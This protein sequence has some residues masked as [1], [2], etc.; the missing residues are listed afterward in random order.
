LVEEVRQAEVRR[1]V[2]PVDQVVLEVEG[3]VTVQVEAELL[4]K[5][6]MAAVLDLLVGKGVAV[7]ALEGVLHLQL[8]VLMVALAQ[9]HRLLAFL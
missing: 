6:I 3:V 8:L 2:L 1:Q 7:L 9:H 5:V 4:V